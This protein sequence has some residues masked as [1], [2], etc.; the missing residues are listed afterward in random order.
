MAWRETGNPPHFSTT[1]LQAGASTTALYAVISSLAAGPYEVRWIVGGSTNAAWALEQA[2]GTTVSDAEQR[3]AA[4]VFTSPNQSA[5][6][7]T[8]HQIEAGDI[9]R[10]RLTSTVALIAAQIQAERLV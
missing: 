9:L 4:Y 2:K 3:V 10:A 6:F 5:E 7:V 8:T 1:S